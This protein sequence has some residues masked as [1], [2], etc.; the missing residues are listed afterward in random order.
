MIQREWRGQAMIVERVVD[1][2]DGLANKL[3]HF[4]F[5]EGPG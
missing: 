3:H 5:P 2:M 1:S 4:A